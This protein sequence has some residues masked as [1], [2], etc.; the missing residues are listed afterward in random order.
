MCTPD[1]RSGCPMC[2]GR[3]YIDPPLRCAYCHQPRWNDTSVC[4]LPLRGVHRMPYCADTCSVWVMTG[5]ETVKNG[6]GEL[7]A[8]LVDLP[9]SPIYI[10]PKRAYLR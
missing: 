4:W 2:S 1:T 5:R 3:G 6:G 8:A 7:W 9:D 10:D